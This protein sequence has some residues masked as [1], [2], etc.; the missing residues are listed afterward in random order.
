MSVTLEEQI[1]ILKASARGYMMMA[2]A[3]ENAGYDAG[4]YFREEIKCFEMA[5]ELEV[6]LEELNNYM[7]AA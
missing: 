6:Q 5:L 1:E 7:M 2:L 3:L 4:H